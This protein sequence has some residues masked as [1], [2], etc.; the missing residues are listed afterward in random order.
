MKRERERTTSQTLTS[1]GSHGNRGNED[2]SFAVSLDFEVLYVLVKALLRVYYGNSCTPS[3]LSASRPH[4]RSVVY[5]R[6]RC[7]NRF[8]A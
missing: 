4:P 3:A 7:L 8:V 6:I 5:E 2:F 1:T